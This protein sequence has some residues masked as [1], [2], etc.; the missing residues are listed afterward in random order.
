MQIFFI[1]SLGRGIILTNCK[2]LCF[3]NNT[4][5]SSDCSVLRPDYYNRIVN[6]NSESNNILERTQVQHASRKKMFVCASQKK[7]FLLPSYL[8]WNFDCFLVLQKSPQGKII[9]AETI[10]Q[11]VKNLFHH[12]ENQVTRQLILSKTIIAN[13]MSS[14]QCSY[15]MLPMKKA[16]RSAKR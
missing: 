3:T 11:N 14:S 8:C 2:C 10:P 16:I 13:R 7:T 5:I 12:S 1:E 6:F 15:V 9:L 4:R